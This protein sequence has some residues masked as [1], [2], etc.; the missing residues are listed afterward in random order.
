MLKR[1][2]VSDEQIEMMMALVQKNP[3][4]FKR[5]AEEIQAKIKDGKDQ[6]QAALEVMMSH[7]DELQE[8][9]KGKE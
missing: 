3:E 5:I 8:I 7:K 2:G 6:Q 4:L 1:Q 9:L